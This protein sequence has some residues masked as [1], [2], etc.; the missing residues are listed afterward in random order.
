MRR[1]RINILQAS[2]R[3]IAHEK[4]VSGLFPDVTAIPFSRQIHQQVKEHFPLQAI[5]A[6]WRQDIT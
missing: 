5:G 6:E 3:I 2:R 4:R 1:I